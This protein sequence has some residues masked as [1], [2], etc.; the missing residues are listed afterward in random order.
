MLHYVGV[1]PVFCVSTVLISLFL[2]MIWVRTKPEAEQELEAEA[3][4]ESVGTSIA[5]TSD[6]ISRICL[7]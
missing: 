2:H 1:T 5:S 3:E 6:S 4:A 7:S